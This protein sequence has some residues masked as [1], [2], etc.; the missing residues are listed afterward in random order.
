MYGLAGLLVGDHAIAEDAVQE[1]LLRAWRNLPHL[2]EPA[3][4]QA[5]LR[6]LVVNASRD[7]GRKLGRRRRDV[8]LEWQHEPAA[9]DQLGTVLDRDQLCR[10]FRLLNTPERAVLALRYYLD[11]SGAAAAATLGI[12]ELTYR[13]RVH[14]ALRALH[15]ILAAEERRTAADAESEARRQIGRGYPRSADASDRFD[16]HPGLAVSSSPRAS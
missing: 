4:F 8:A 15:A 11:L 2:R 9:G 3:R 7:L 14:R 13:S 6:S 5:W 1:A 12:P 16:G 10:A